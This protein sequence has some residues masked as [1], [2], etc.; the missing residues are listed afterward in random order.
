MPGM[1]HITRQCHAHGNIQNCYHAFV[2]LAGS[3]RLIGHVSTRTSA[4]ADI[5]VFSRLPYQ[6]PVLQQS[7]LLFNRP[8][9]AGWKHWAP[10]VRTFTSR[11]PSGAGRKKKTSEPLEPTDSGVAAQAKTPR[12]RAAAAGRANSVNPGTATSS[13]PISATA[14]LDETTSSAGSDTDPKPKTKR[15]SRTRA[16]AKEEGGETVSSSPAS[17]KAHYEILDYKQSAGLPR[18]DLDNLQKLVDELTSTNAK[19]GKVK[20]LGQYPGIAPL[21]GWIYDPLRQFNVR[22]SN[23]IKHAQRRAL[24]RDSGDPPPPLK[25]RKQSEASLEETAGYSTLSSL[26]TALSTRAITGHAALDAILIFMEQYCSDVPSDQIHKGASSLG[27]GHKDALEALLKT[28]RS[29]LLLKILDKNLKAGCSVGSIRE[30]YPNLIPGF[31][32]ALG[33]GL[34][35]LDEAHKLFVDTSEAT[36]FVEDKKKSGGEK[37]PSKKTTRARQPSRVD[38][39][40]AESGPNPAWFASRKLDGVRCLIRIDRESGNMQ[41]LSRTGKP[42]ESMSIIQEALSDLVGLKEASRRDQFFAWIVGPKMSDDQETTEPLPDSIVLDGELCVFVT[43]PEPVEQGDT[44]GKNPINDSDGR[45]GKGGGDNPPETT[46]STEGDSFGREHFLKAISFARRESSVASENGDGED[47][48]DDQDDSKGSLSKRGAS[49]DSLL[50]PFS[51]RPV[52]CLFDCLT[53]QEFDSRTGIK[54][55]SQRIRAVTEAIE[56]MRLDGR[57]L[58]NTRKGL[59]YYDPT[60]MIKVLPQTKITKFE[61]LQAMVTGGMAKGWEGVMLRR[62]VGYEGKR[63]RHLLKIKQ[64]QD[65]EFVVQDVLL[66]KLRLPVEGEFKERDNV[67][68]SVVISHRG[69]QV[70][71][72]SGFSV[73]DRIRFGKDP[74]LIIG[75]TITVQYF[76]ESQSIVVGMGSPPSQTPKVGLEECSEAS[77]S[78]EWSLRFPTVKAIYDQ[79]PRPM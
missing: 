61:Q 26:L 75:K 70:R 56:G 19:S 17:A 59:D 47:K 43:E 7:P 21:L 38:P 15:T 13:A 10:Q 45:R 67:L 34:G 16:K 78:G 54:P 24:E 32:V 68:T 50:D 1:L 11:T 53:G 65:A 28:R 35:N 77:D 22:P 25:T 64:F 51:D 40:E 3:S 58:R 74:S 52:Y 49:N 4:V 76:E 73:E 2:N 66:G 44:E 57:G 71:V 69:N 14:D 9:R 12:K 5:R 20:I 46:G 27:L 36:L 18:D 60:K 63:S 30:V 48:D 62:D 39:V 23:I 33:K 41:A 42:F 37:G 8:S 29:Q 31:H 72:G 6:S 55:F 79:G